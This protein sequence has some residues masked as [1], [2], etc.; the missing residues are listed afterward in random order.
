[1]KKNEEISPAST[2]EVKSGYSFFIKTALA[3]FSLFTIYNMY[4]AY[5]KLSFLDIGNESVL[6]TILTFADKIGEIPTYMAETFF[7][8]YSDTI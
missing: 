8:W 5:N 2:E 1:M 4:S 7:E 6:D 3:T